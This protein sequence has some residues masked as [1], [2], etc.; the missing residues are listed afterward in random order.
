MTTTG[1]VIGAICISVGGWRWPFLVAAPIAAT[2]AVV[3]RRLL[4]ESIDPDAGPIPDLFGSVL[5]VLGVAALALAIVESGTWGA[6][7]RR[8]LGAVALAAAVLTTFVVRCARHPVPVID[9]RVFR[10]VAF[11]ATAVCALAMG[12]AFYASYYLFVVVLLQGWDYT[13]LSAGFLLVPMTLGA[14][15]IGVPAGR[16]MDRRGMGL[17]M[18]LAAVAMATAMLWLV[19]ALDER[20][21]IGAVWL[22]AVVVVGAASTIFLMGVN[23][24]GTRTAPPEVLGVTAAVVQTLIRVGGAMGSALGV[25]LVASSGTAMDD[26]H[27]AFAA[28]GV[29]AVVAALASVPLV[30]LRVGV[31]TRAGAPT[32]SG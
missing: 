11:R 2:V 10:P 17:P 8:T 1:P 12:V 7:D 15:L 16:W 20:R 26:L 13:V 3:G 18:V 32:A 6:G 5:V 9:L 29:A 31:P 23:S 27:H 24:A 30:V 22:P 28:V 14:S 19:I 4:P 21:E 25:A